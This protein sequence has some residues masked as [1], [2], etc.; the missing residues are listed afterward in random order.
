MPRLVPPPAARGRL[1]SDGMQ[2]LVVV[3]ATFLMCTGIL[4]GW[5]REKPIRQ[6]PKDHQFRRRGRQDAA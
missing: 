3:V 6:N 2:L 5:S 1:T 4:I